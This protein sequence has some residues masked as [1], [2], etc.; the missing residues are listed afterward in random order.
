MKNAPLFHHISIAATHE[1][2]AR[3]ELLILDMRDEL[4]YGLAHIETAKHVSSANVDSVI[5]GTPKTMPVLI[6][7]YHGNASQ[8][9]AQ[10]FS[11]FGFHEVYSLDGGFEAWSLAQANSPSAAISEP[12]QQWLAAQ[13]FPPDGINAPAEHGLTPLMKASRQGNTAVVTALV[14]TGAQLHVRNADGNNTLWLACVGANL[15]VI[16]FLI[17]AG[18]DINNQN[19]SGATCLMYAA[20]SGKADVVE[21]LL[22]AG[23]D[24]QRQTLDDFTALDMAATLECLN[25]LQRSNEPSRCAAY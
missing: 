19:D 9:Y 16:N 14:S 21:A 20:S 17:R 24:A 10:M 2:F 4:S 25:L 12:L 1:L 8:I 3:G 15:E 5:F 7:C 13:G 23:A 11:D 22:A 18:V 6:Y